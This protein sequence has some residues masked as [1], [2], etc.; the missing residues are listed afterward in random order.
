V[1]VDLLPDDLA[2]LLNAMRREVALRCGFFPFFYGLATQLVLFVTGHPPNGKDLGGYIDKFDNQ[3]SIIQ[4]I[5][6]VHH[7]LGLVSA[8]RTWGQSISAKYQDAIA[9]AFNQPNLFSE[10]AKTGDPTP[11]VR[12]HW[13]IYL[14]YYL[15]TSVAIGAGVAVAMLAFAIFGDSKHGSHKPLPDRAPFLFFV[16][17]VGVL[18]V[19]TFL[20][21]L[22]SGPFVFTKD[23]V[24]KQCH[25]RREVNRIPF[26]AGKYSRP[27]RCEC[28]GKVEPAMLWKPDLSRH[29]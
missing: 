17:V 7:E 1:E 2:P 8:A 16:A 18:S 12:K 14:A 3:W 9:A 5:F 24:C 21:Q 13:S 27:P 6:V 15:V 23:V 28:G 20:I 19:I 10:R 26:F 4:S 29:I 22:I 25:K 11:Y